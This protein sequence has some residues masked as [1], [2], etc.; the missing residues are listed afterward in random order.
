M[1][2]EKIKEKIRTIPHWPKKGVMFRDITTLLKDKDGLRQVTDLLL[3]RYK[4]MKIDKIAG[5]ESRGFIFGAA[6]AHALGIG[7]V[8]IR[9]PG[10]LPAAT[11]RVECRTEY[12]TDAL[13]IHKDAIQNGDK[14][15]LVDD[16][17]ATAGTCIAAANLITQLGGEIVECAFVVELPDL[18]GKERIEREGYTVFS[19]TQ[20]EGN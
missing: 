20:F 15:L 18:R 10:K 17:V 19:L 5:I 16:L 8:P 2:H 11:L 7:F 14:I 12:S 9:K 13:E 1:A 3:N 4:H 6:L